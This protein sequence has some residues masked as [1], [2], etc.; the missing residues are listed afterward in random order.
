MFKNKFEMGRLMN[1]ES[2]SGAGGAGGTG[3]QG[4]AEQESKTVSHDPAELLKKLEAIERT[5][6]DLFAETKQLKAEKK[7]REDSDKEK[8]KKEAEADRNFEKLY[9]IEIEAKRELAEKLESYE[10]TQSEERTK[11]IKTQMWNAFQK[12]LGVELVDPE[13]A[14]SLVN[15]DKFQVDEQSKYGFN[16]DGIKQAVN[17]FRTKRSYLLKSVESKTP[18]NAAKSTASD[19]S[20]KSFAERMADAGSILSKK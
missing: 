3:N 4:G 20:K 12:E 5:N 16:E 17:E 15:W 2:D 6:K 9:Q 18:Q 7:L 10:R 13:L 11:I 1:S 14:M 19:P 8:S